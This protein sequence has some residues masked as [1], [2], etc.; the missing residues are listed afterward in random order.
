MSERS[1]EIPNTRAAHSVCH[2][3][4]ENS[5]LPWVLSPRSS[6]HCCHRVALRTKTLNKSICMESPNEVVTQQGSRWDKKIKRSRGGRWSWTFKLAQERSWAGRW[7]WAAKVGLL[8]LQ[9]VPQQQCNGYCPCDSAQH[10]SWNSNCAVHK[11]LG[12]GEGT[13]P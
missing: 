13:P 12:N 1:I 3:Y 7:N 2:L 10:G 8:S 4:H 6:L 5:R 11:S 9:V